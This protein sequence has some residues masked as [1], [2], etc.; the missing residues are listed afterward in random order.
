MEQKEKIKI[1][2]F[3]AIYVKQKGSANKA[4]ASLKVSPAVISH[5]L[6]GNFEPYSDAM[7]RKIGVGVGYNTGEL[8]FVETTN[9]KL[10]KDHIDTA[11]KVKSVITVLG[12]A[13][14]GKSKISQNY[15]AN[16]SDV[17]RIRCANHWDERYFLEQLLKAMGI[18][19]SQN[20]V[21]YMMEAVIEGVLK[22]DVP[23]T[24]FIDEIDKLKDAILMFFI[25]FYDDVKRKCTVVLFSTNYFKKRL[26][27]GVRNRK[28]GFAEL[29]SRYST[30]IEME[31]TSAADVKLYCE[32]QGIMDKSIIKIIQKKS[33][34]DLR[35]VEELV[36]VYKL[37]NGI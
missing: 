16:N 37:E 10:L 5:L 7:F 29:S 13:G 30:F 26:E 1:A 12:D 6:N 36:I 28:K 24:L 4:A 31:Q 22:Y 21:P 8:V 34:C 23:P 15:E 19:N 2:D 14:S 11:K 25:P 27:D 9:A 32:A 20:K 18:K 3:L 33:N 17:I 35:I